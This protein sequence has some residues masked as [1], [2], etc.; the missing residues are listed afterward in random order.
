MGRW[1]L[2][3]AGDALCCAAGEDGAGHVHPWETSMVPPGNR[4][5][6]LAEFVPYGAGVVASPPCTFAPCVGL[7]TRGGSGAVGTAAQFPSIN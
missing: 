1:E 6:F 4:W 7:G 2:S 5:L 3:P